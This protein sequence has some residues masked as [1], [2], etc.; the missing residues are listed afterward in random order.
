MG[1]SPLDRT[2]LQT[3]SSGAYNR[4]V[5]EGIIRDEAAPCC[6]GREAACTS[7]GWRSDQACG[8]ARDYDAACPAV[9]CAVSEWTERCGCAEPCRATVRRR[10]RVVVQEPLNAG[11]PCPHLEEH[12]GCAE[13]WSTRGHCPSALVP[14]LITTGG[15][16]NT[17]KK[18][19]TPD[20]VD[21]IGYYVQTVQKNAKLRSFSTSYT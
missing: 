15:Y 5:S 9:S 7:E 10:S 13:Y 8:A 6:P 2:A 21:I 3:D 11:T 14:A 19:D 18:R 12:A 1:P 20:S 4:R 16:G 17:R